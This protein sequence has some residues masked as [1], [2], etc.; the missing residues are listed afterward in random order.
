MTTCEVCDCTLDGE[1]MDMPLR[2]GTNADY[3]C[4]YTCETVLHDTV[5]GYEV[6]VDSTA[7]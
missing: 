4:C 5:S 3:V 6:S 2:L 1:A 7:T